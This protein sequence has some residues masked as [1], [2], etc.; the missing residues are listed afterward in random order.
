M[1]AQRNADV[2]FTRKALPAILAV[3]FVVGAIFVPRMIKEKACLSG[4]WTQAVYE[5]EDAA[6]QGTETS[7]ELFGYSG[8]GYVTGFDKQTDSLA[9]TVDASRAATC[10]LTLVYAAPHGEKTATLVVNGRTVRDVPLPETKAFRKLSVGKIKL[11]KGANQVTLFSNWGWYEIDRIELHRAGEKAEAPDRLQPGLKPVN[12]Q[13]SAA[14]MAL[15]SYLN[16]RQGRAVLAGQQEYDSLPWIEQS[17]GKLPAIVGFDLMDYS[18]SRVARGA[19][20][21][22]TEKAIAWHERG[23]I[24]T[25]VWHWNAPSGLLELEEEGKEWWSGFYT[26][27]TAFD[28]AD[29]LAHPESEDYRLLLAD[30]DAAAA[31]L[32]KLRDAGVPVLFRPLHEAEGGWF[33]WG[34]KGPGPAVELYRLLYDRLTNVHK[35]DNLIWVW[36]STAPEW[37]PGDD[38]VDIVSYDSYPR[39]G[40][41]GPAQEAYARLAELTGGR[42]LIAMSENGPV[43]DPDAMFK[44][45]A[46]WSW[47]CTWSGDHLTDGRSND[48]E[49]LR[50]VYNHERVVTLDEL[51]DWEK[52][53]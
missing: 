52:T 29:T 22:E 9:F 50:R 45:G 30:M 33:W 37:Y 53:D 46:T 24:V 14:A 35:L 48:L 51:P 10:T 42:K 28:I 41:Y 3:A 27:A 16:G 2:K 18:L 19:K 25:F 21:S 32:G 49:H 20:S 36:N 44:D 12:P 47:F 5:A 8:T 23:G 7:T 26:E 39:P 40:D 17:T 34:A 1:R 15:L 38:L 4:D 31:Q 13:A 11:V 6:G 43:P